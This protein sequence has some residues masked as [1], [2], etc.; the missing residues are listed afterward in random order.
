MTDHVRPYAFSSEAPVVLDWWAKWV[1]DSEAH[2]EALKRI[3]PQVAPWEGAKTAVTGAF[4]SYRFEGFRADGHAI[5]ADWRVV[6]QGKW[7]VP[8][9]STKEGKR[10][11]KLMAEV[12]KWTDPRYRP[13]IPGVK[14]D[15]FFS[16][17]PAFGIY[18]EVAWMHWGDEWDSLEIVD[19]TI[20]T[21]RRMSEFYI[22]RE[23]E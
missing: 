22:A 9:K 20:W 21:V 4:G 5:P 12:P 11:V 1:S 16:A 8:K 14:S 2:D 17:A 13:G 10:L 3:A 23:A 19:Q 7:V 15:Y 18:N 6:A